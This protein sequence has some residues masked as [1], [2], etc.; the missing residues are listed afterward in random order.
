MLLV[1]TY[2]HGHIVRLYLSVNQPLQLYP[3]MFVFLWY[4]I[5]G[6]DCLWKTQ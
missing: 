3:K 1:L 2:M 5:F 4:V 6:N